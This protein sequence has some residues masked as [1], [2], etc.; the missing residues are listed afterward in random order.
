ME[1]TFYF[2]SRTDWTAVK[3]DIKTTNF[4]FITSSLPDDAAQQFQTYLQQLL[5]KHVPTR[6]ADTSKSTHLWINDRVRHAI[7]MKCNAY[8]TDAFNTTARRTRAIIMEEYTNYQQRL[9][10]TISQ[11]ERGSKEWWKYNRQLLNKNPK[12]PAYHHY[13]TSTTNGSTTHKPKPTY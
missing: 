10:H 8:N 2:F 9:R 4:D 3:H 12:S 6:T 5:R 13:E 7:N 11:L 1:R